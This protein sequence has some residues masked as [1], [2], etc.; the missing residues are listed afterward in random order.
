MGQISKTLRYSRDEVTTAIQS[1][2]KKKYVKQDRRDEVNRDHEEATFFTEPSKRKQIDRNLPIGD[3]PFLRPL[4][5]FICHSSNDKPAVRLL[6]RRLITE[7]IDAWLDEERL[8]SG[9]DFNFEIA[10]AVRKADVVIVCLSRESIIKAGFIQKEIKYALDVA[11]E[12]PEGA[13]FLIPLKLQEC[14]VPERLRRW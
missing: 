10:K 2:L 12:Q 13:I 8:L 3:F 9:Q 7:N 11:D 6:Y 14:E 1:L 4:R 5:V